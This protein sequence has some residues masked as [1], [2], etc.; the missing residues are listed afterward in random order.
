MLAIIYTGE[1]RTIEK[2]IDYFLK[3]VVSEKTHV[4]AV[5]QGEHYDSFVRQ[6]L[7]DKLKSLTWFRNEQEWISLRESLLN[8]MSC[9][10]MW[11]NYLRRS[12]SMIEYYQMYLAYKQI[13]EQEKLGEK[14]D[15]IM[16]MR[17]DVVLTEPINIDYKLCEEVKEE[18][19]VRF[20]NSFYHPKRFHQ[21]AGG[22]NFYKIEG[23]FKEYFEKG[24]YIITLRNNI[25][26]FAN[27]ETFRKISNL[28]ITYGKYVLQ[29]DYWFNAENQLRGI[30]RANQID[31]F[32]SV[33]QLEDKSLYEYNEN[34]YF[35]NG[36]LKTDC[37]FFIRR[38]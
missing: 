26:Y 36:E 10:D 15:Y 22:P 5:L 35:E 13:E 38:Y 6:K 23:S 8:D 19:Y 14:Y 31:I 33:M 4:F 1:V 29:D 27:R 21:D 11:K 24:N 34:N 37:L 18:D 7:G 28:G 30:C 3:N 17:C 12:G 2:T 32:D 20:M 9:P 16:R 25:I